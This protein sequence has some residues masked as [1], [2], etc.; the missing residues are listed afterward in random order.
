MLERMLKRECS[1]RFSKANRCLLFLF[2][3]MRGITVEAMQAGLEMIY[4]G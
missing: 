3:E 1:Y 4:P 2:L